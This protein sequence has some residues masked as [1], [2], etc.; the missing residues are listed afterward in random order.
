MNSFVITTAVVAHAGSDSVVPGFVSVLLFLVFTYLH[1][2]SRQPYFRAWQLAWAAYSLYWAAYS[3]YYVLGTFP[4]SSVAFFIS[5]L[6]L[7]AMALCIFV[8]TRMM[9]GPSPLRWYDAAVGAGGVILALLT[10]HG[11]ILDGIFKP[12]ARPAIQLGIGLAAILL[13][14]S[15]VF[16]LNGHWRGSLAFQV[17]SW[18]LAFWGVLLLVDQIQNPWMK[19]F[20]NA[21]R[22]FGPVP[23][24]LLG[25]A[26]VMVLF[27]NQ[28]NAV[29]E[30]TLALSTLGADPRRLLFA[31]DLVPNM[32]AALARLRTAI[33]IDCAAIVISERWRGVLPSVQQNFAPGFLEALEVSGTGEYISELAF[34]HSGI[35]TVHD[36]A[37]M[38]EPLPLGPQGTFAEFKR[39]DRKSVV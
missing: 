31:E 9:R 16:Y 11:H 4:Y 37:E 33:P 30:N 21:S 35:Y 20:D 8:S 25:I 1:E 2:Q 15:A 27:E 32:R 28:R 36:V 3:L 29:Q 39:I 13:Y 14:S 22:L 26:M 7:V 6:F 34:R 23:Q 24:M 18:A 38:T 10:L 19:M 12:D 5:Q 17:L